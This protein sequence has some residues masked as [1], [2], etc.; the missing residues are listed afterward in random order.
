MWLCT[1]ENTKIPGVDKLQKHSQFP[2][3][4]EKIN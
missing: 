1:S 4:V 2:L 3:K